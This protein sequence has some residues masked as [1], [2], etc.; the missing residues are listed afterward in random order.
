MTNLKNNKMIALWIII[1]LIGTTLTIW[2]SL[3]LNDAWTK[4]DE[5]KK[6]HPIPDFILLDCDFEITFSKEQTNIIEE[7][8]YSKI[9]MPEGNVSDINQLPVLIFFNENREGLE[10][11]ALERNIL[12]N[13]KTV[14]VNGTATS[15]DSTTLISFY[16][17]ENNI[18][19]GSKEKSK[20]SYIEILRYNKDEGTFTGRMNNIQLMTEVHTASQYLLDL[21]QITFHI[22]FS[23]QIKLRKVENVYLKTTRTKYFYI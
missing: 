7:A 19:I 4:A 14:I 22:M 20:E 17:N 2:G 15:K 5:L 16:S 11:Y 21:N 9:S 8:I 3:K 10:K 6:Q 13:L 12:N 23:G 1:I 18:Y